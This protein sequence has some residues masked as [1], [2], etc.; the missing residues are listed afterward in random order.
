MSNWAFF[1]LFRLVVVG[2]LLLIQFACYRKIRS[3]ISPAGRSGAKMKI[4]KSAFVVMNVPLF[5]F[6]FWIPKL[7][8]ASRLTTVLFIYPFY[9]WHVS[10]L[11]IGLMVLMVGVAAAP[12]KIS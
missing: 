8:T 3:S 6:V 2:L 7:L 11:V 12:F 5:V 10:F 4:I 1:N 9:I